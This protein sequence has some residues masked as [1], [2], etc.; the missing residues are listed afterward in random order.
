MY[1]LFIFLLLLL[2][3][4]KILYDL[5]FRK[6]YRK[7]LLY[8]LGLKSFSFERKQDDFVIWIHAVSLGETR[9]GKELV[10]KIQQSHPKAKIVFS[11]GT[12]TGHAE[13][14][15]IAG[16]CAFFLPLDFSW[17]MRKLVQKIRPQLLILIETD[18]WYHHLHF[19]KLSGA[20]ILLV[21]GKISKKSVRL[22]RVFTSFSQKLFGHFDLFSVQN[23]TYKKRFETAGADPQ[24]I[25]VTGNLKY[26]QNTP[27]LSSQELRGWKEKMG[28]YE[29]DHVVTIASTHA[30][31]EKWLAGQMQ[32][33]WQRDPDIK[34]L[35]APRHPERFASVASLLRAQN[36]PF[37]ALSKLHLKK[38]TEKVILIDAMG[39]LPICYQLSELAI[40]GGSFTDKIGGHNILEPNFYHVPV[41][42]GPYMAAQADLKKIV[43][44][45]KAG[46]QVPLG[47]IAD[48]LESFFEDAAYRAQLKEATKGLIH[49]LK[50]RL[51]ETYRAIEPF[52]GNP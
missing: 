50:G 27:F 7:A 36:I 30:P 19:A 10:Q 16:D 20:K 13:A 34:I 37:I 4:P 25:V 9:S 12:E 28:I 33:V 48:R 3:L 32:K 41:F 35:L 26:D 6:K 17:T 46:A 43:L 44:T 8:R 52:L 39:F 2:Y 14:R 24:K 29:E 1:N 22:Y 15:R 21:S 18:F 5:L 45:A 49:S 47:E 38:S 23:N 11:S 42:F 51:G 31:E 40:I